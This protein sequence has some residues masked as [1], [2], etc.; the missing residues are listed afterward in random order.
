MLLYSTLYAEDAA[1]K[2]EKIAALKVLKQF[3]T[4]VA[5]STSFEY[6]DQPLRNFFKDIITVHRDRDSGEVT[7]YIL[8][9]GD[10]GCNGG[11]GTYA[12]YVSEVYRY[13]FDRSFAVM[14]YNVFDDI[15]PDRINPRFIESVKML[16]P[17]RFTI[18]SSEFAKGDANNFPSINY[19]YSIIR[20][21]GRRWKIIDRERVYLKP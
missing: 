8:W 11:S 17:N 7:Y 4:T 13:H 1:I 14:D 2:A 18:V 16:N 3:T 15:A 12:H 20:L 5:C 21:K 10:L 9:G 6:P 19:R